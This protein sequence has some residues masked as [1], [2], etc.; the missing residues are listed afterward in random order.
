MSI[1]NTQQK[2]IFSLFASV[3]APSS[4]IPKYSKA[5]MLMLARASS[6]QLLQL[7]DSSEE[8]GVFGSCAPTM[9]KPLISRSGST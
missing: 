8:P 4:A 6:F 9:G 5:C 7:G 3:K 2:R 1:T